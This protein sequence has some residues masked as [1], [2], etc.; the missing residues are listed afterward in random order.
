MFPGPGRSMDAQGMSTGQSGN[1]CI[2]GKEKPGMARDCN[3]RRPIG[4]ARDKD[5]KGST[6]DQDGLASGTL[7]GGRTARESQRMRSQGSFS[8]NGKARTMR[9]GRR[10]GLLNPFSK[11]IPVYR[12]YRYF[13]IPLKKT[14]QNLH[15][16]H[17]ILQ[18]RLG[19]C[20]A[21]T[22]LSDNTASSAALRSRPVTASPLPG[23]EESNCPR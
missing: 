8:R 13:F 23:R 6:A 20:S 3:G 10:P 18:P 14:L 2:A 16:F 15:C 21:G 17:L 5:I 19:T 9:Q 12:P 7:S 4:I 11:K 22:A 1:G